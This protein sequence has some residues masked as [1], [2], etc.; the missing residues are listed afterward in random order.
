MGRGLR[1]RGSG[2]LEVLDRTLVLLRSLP[3]SERSK[4]ASL[5]GFWVLLAGVQA[6]LTAFQFSYHGDSYARVESDFCAA[7]AFSSSAGFYGRLVT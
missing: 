1:S 5:S 4:V 2:T 3:R 6:I 7:V